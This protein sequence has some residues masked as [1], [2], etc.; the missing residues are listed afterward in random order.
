[1][2]DRA[3]NYASSRRSE[4]LRA[5]ASLL[6][7]G[8]LAQ[9]AASCS[10][11]DPLPF[12]DGS[13]ATSTTAGS[14]GAGGGGGSG[15][16][17]GG[18][19][20]DDC[21]PGEICVDGDHCEA[22]CPEGR[23]AC[24]LAGGTLC[25]ASG[26]QC[27]EASVF[28]YTGGDLCRPD[29]EAC[30]VGCPGGEESCALGAFCEMDPATEA[31]VCKDECAAGKLCDSNLC[32][33][34][35]SACVE[36]AC[37]LADLAIDDQRIQ[38]SVSVE[39]RYFDADACEIQEGCVGAP[40]NRMLLRFDLKTPNVGADLELGD[41]QTS[42][43]FHYSDC[44]GHY[45]FDGYADYRLQNG[46][47]IEVGSGHKQAFCLLDFERV[48]DNAATDAR[49][50]CGFQG[51]QAGWADIYGSYLPCQWVDVTDVAPGD[52]TLKV[53]LNKD[54]VLAEASYDNN[55]ALV[56]VT[57]PVNSCVNGCRVDDAACC[58]PG[59]PCGWGNDGSCDCADYFGWDGA[60]CSSCLD[61]SPACDLDNTCPAGC[62][63]DPGG[64]CGAVDSCGLANDG[65][66]DCGGLAPWDALD[67]S[68][69][70]TPSPSCPVN[71]CPAGCTGPNADPCC[72]NAQGCTTWIADGWCD[73][74]GAAWDAADCALCLTLDPA[75]P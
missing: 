53:S 35:G 44:H 22:G 13:A 69:C 64:C 51:I 36:S 63:A 41:P 19:G 52:Y 46:Q 65:A 62:P 50:D 72:G 71:T 21:G 2:Y 33:P 61:T 37:P 7:L 43:G 8:L 67:C 73:C 28:G 48:D 56:P 59:D 27:C 58:A 70:T 10:E 66:C 47:G 18:D 42:A 14:G 45:H 17:G 11:D 29:G 24:A 1:M 12:D 15:G 32:C 57:V 5:A 75:C 54:R 23:D 16:A 74:G 39:V 31:Y 68:A 9:M 49:Y 25:C 3:V 38:D 26:E 40:G 6:V 55:V 30:P 20:C 4:G 34:L 60:D